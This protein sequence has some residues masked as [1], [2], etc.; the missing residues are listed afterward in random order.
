MLNE[1]DPI[2]FHREPQPSN[3]DQILAE[4]FQMTNSRSSLTIS[5][6]HCGIIVQPGDLCFYL[7]YMT[8]CGACTS[9]GI[10]AWHTKRTRCP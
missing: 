3:L 10:Q 2:L 5:C 6:P 4:M 9:E 1:K 8:T 7:P